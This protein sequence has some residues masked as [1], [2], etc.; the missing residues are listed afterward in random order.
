MLTPAQKNDLLARA[1]AL[2]VR[3]TEFV[4]EAIGETHQGGNVI[5]SLDGIS[6][7]ITNISVEM[8]G[9]WMLS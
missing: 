1:A 5:N 4:D 7:D 6:S 8:G 9:T 3:A 2:I